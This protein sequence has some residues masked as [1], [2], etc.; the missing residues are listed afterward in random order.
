MGSLSKLQTVRGPGRM[1]AATDRRAPSPWIDV[2]S[3]FALA[4]GTHVTPDLALTLSHV[5]SAVDIISGDFGT[6][7]CQLFEDMGERDGYA[8]KRKVKSSD[9]GVGR[10]AYQLRWQPNA[11]QTAKAFFSTLAWQYLLR[12]FCF[13]EL[14]YRAG[15]DSYIDQFVPRSPD[16][17]T[18]ERLP[19]GRVRF[20]LS[21]EPDGKP[22]YLTQDEALIVRN[23]STDGLNALSRIAYGAKVLASAIAL[24]EFTRNYFE[25]GATAALIAT[26]K[27]GTMEPAEEEKFHG[28]ISR[29]M[30]GVDN[31]GG[32]FVSDEDMDIKNLGVEPEKAQ[33]LGLKNISGRD[34]ARLFKMPPSWLGIE[35]TSGYA[36]EVQD[37]LNYTKRCQTPMAVEFEQAIQRD[38]IVAP[39]GQYYAK[40]NLDYLTR[41]TLKERMESYEIGIRAR[42][43]RPS[44][45]RERED[46]DPDPEL[47][48]LSAQDHRAGSQRDGAD[49]KPKGTRVASAIAVRSML[50]AHDSAMRVLGREKA[51]VEKIAKKHADNVDGWK[52]ELKAFYAD[53]ATM[54][55]ETMRLPIDT[56]RSVAARHG[57]TLV[58]HGIVAMDTN[59]E[60]LEA[61]ALV[62]LA[63][64]PESSFTR[65]ADAAAQ[66]SAS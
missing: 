21:G 50:F 10:V 47:D 26:Y 45:A 3:G 24:Q 35:G 59:W 15:S 1:M 36:S 33:L 20:K 30:S 4:A 14:V 13:A 58:D 41:A 57:Q 64:D 63:M 27:G 42:V 28:R 11:W 5:Y 39:G 62:T 40:F 34:V 17:I 29:F 56:A 22:R 23:T 55:A 54:I 66:E 7:T 52:A 32:I 51:A 38:V 53:H 46:L 31:A 19:S 43:I 65:L 60:R 6:N 61:E 16:R 9:A 25:H 8:V 2:S 48:E 44:E 49:N 12:P 18:Q 37:G